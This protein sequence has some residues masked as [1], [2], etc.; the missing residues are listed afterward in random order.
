METNSLYYFSESAKDL[1]FTKTAK[2]LFISQQNLSNHIA[3][4]EHYY[5]VK[6]FER[7]PHLTLTYAGEVL[8]AYAKNFKMDEDNLKNVL[9]D[10]KE[11]ERGTLRIGCSPIRTSIVMPLLVEEFTREYPNVELYLY[12]HHTNKLAEMMLAGELDFSISVDK[13]KHPNLI[14][15]PLFSDT[16][17]LMVS[18]HLMDIYFGANTD[19]L[20]ERSRSGANLKDFLELPFVNIIST[21]IIR[22]CFTS[23]GCEPNFLVTTSAPQ[24]SLPNFYENISASIVT[25]TIYLHIREHVANHILFFPLITSKAMALHDISFIRH[26]RKYLTKYGQHFL[27]VTENYFKKLEEL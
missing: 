9:S 5:G 26:R 14:S 4:L 25:K 11:K 23:I 17:Y 21:Q 8:L 12:H 19:E 22:D 6:L 2:R 20:V 15:T 13:I 10:I 3:R 18:R 27:Y 24:F 1:N 16:I 7:K